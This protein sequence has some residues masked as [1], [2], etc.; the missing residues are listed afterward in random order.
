MKSIMRHFTKRDWLAT[1][2]AVVL[3]GLSVWL[4]LLMPDYMKDITELLIIPGSSIGDLLWAGGKML[5]CAL[6]SLVV[7]VLVTVVS[8]YLAA[9]YSYNVRGKL[10]DAVEGFSMAEINRF[11]TAS[12]ITRS[13]NDITQ[14]QTIIV[15]GLFVIV[16]APLMA[17]LAIT[18][19]ADKS[20]EWTISAGVAVVLVIIVLG[21]C[22]LFAHPRFKRIQTLTDNINRITRENLTGLRVVRAY[23]AE[24]YQKNKFEQANE[25]ITKNNM[26]AHRIMSIMMPS[27]MLIMNGLS[28]IVYWIGAYLIDGAPLAGKAELFLDMTV[29]SQYALMVIMAF[30]MLNMI[31]IMG[32]RS[33]IAAKRINEV[34]DTKSSVADGK[35][36]EHTDKEGEIE[37]KNVSFKYPDAADYVLKDISFTAKK[38]ETIAIIGSTG[39]GKSTLINLIPRFYDASEGEVLV[40]GVNVRDYTLEQLHNKLGYVPQRAVLFSGTI[41]TNIAMG[42]NGTEGYTQDDVKRAAA[43]AQ[44]KDYIE[45]YPEQY[46]HPVAQGGSNLSGGQKQRVCI[47][48]AICRRPEIMIFDDSFSALDYKTDSILRKSLKEETAGTT[49]IIVAQRIGTIKDADLIIVLDEG[50]IVGMG[51]HRELLKTCQVYHEIGLSQLGEEELNYA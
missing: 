46:E 15:F 31:F 17:V 42:S 21:V 25:D 20:A 13:T 38:G 11:S 35:G 22:F 23:N 41:N 14:V 47:A 9:N 36:V 5:L 37:F 4:E 34:I 19:I 43:I 44:A 40:D 12:L 6:A 32:P 49:N 1:L 48:R 28:L 8:G 33:M 29:F 18:K 7:S 10:Y 39:C 3:I 27:M 26:T 45:N 51:K 24:D 50:R 2:G 30:M 16:R